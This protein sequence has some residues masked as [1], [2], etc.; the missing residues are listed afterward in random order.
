[1]QKVYKKL[2]ADQKRRGVIF[3]ST[4]SYNRRDDEMGQRTHE[5][6]NDIFTAK[7]D[8][9]EAGKS[10]CEWLAYLPLAEKRNQETIDRLLNDS[11]FNGSGWKYNIIRK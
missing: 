6:Y 1:M 9:A 3:S 4:L 5:V 8:C 11:F 2:T 7:M 10:E